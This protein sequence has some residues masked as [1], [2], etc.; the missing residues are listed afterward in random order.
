MAEE[1]LIWR[2]KGKEVKITSLKELLDTLVAIK[3]EDAADEMNVNL[4]N[5]IRWLNDNFS[6]NIGLI[7]NVQSGLKEFSPQQFRELMIRKI[8]ALG[9]AC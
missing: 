2:S 6:E 5:M 1:E 9:Q 8:K 3:E 4:S 7:Q